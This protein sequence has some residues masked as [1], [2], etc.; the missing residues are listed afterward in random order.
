MS[1]G[2]ELKTGEAMA[3]EAMTGRGP[4]ARSLSAVQ[5]FI[6]ALNSYAGLM[7][8]I[9]GVVGALFL[10]NEWNERQ[11]EARIKAIEALA[12]TTTQSRAALAYL[13]RISANLSHQDLSGVNV[14][15]LVLDDA[16]LSDARFDNANLI[17]TSLS[18]DLGALSVRCADISN[19]SLVNK[20]EKRGVD[21]RGARISM[22]GAT[23]QHWQSA[24]L[25]TPEATLRQVAKNIGKN[26]KGELTASEYLSKQA[27]A[28]PDTSLPYC[29]YERLRAQGASHDNLCKGGMS[30]D[31]I[32]CE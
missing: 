28:S 9:L 23:I 14:S 24:V 31:G 5:R 1:D 11:E 29:L 15:G 16:G 30:W 8:V 32:N 12:G 18:G 6:F 22:E 3:S 21:A 27:G 7:N 26:L 13:A 19:L 2:N 4:V 20:D 17:N 25:Y 10:V